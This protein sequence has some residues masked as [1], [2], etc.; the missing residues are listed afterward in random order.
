MERDTL[1]GPKALSHPCY[2]LCG[3]QLFLETRLFLCSSF[4][5]VFFVAPKDV[6]SQVDVKDAVVVCGKILILCIFSVKRTGV[7]KGVQI[8]ITTKREHWANENARE[9]IH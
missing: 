5:L 1:V 4:C 8:H 9:T 2:R 6:D 7:V 3:F